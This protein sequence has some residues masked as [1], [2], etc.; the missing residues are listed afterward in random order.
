MELECF[1]L[2]AI[3]IFSHLVEENDISEDSL[4]CDVHILVDREDNIF[5]IMVIDIGGKVRE[6]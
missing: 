6:K 3:N 1:W 2:V 4:E 5:L